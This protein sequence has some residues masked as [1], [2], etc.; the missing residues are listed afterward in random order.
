MKKA[1]LK[2]VVSC[3]SGYFNPFDTNNIVDVHKYLIERT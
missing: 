1:V 2:G 3:F